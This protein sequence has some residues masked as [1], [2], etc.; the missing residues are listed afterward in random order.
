MCVC[1]CAEQETPTMDDMDLADLDALA[2]GEREW[3]T[4]PDAD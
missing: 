1:A 3:L 4:E 2:A